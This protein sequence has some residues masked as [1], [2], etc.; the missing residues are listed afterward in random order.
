MK[1]N[2]ERIIQLLERIEELRRRGVLRE[3]EYEE[4]RA[5]L[6]RQLK[7]VKPLRRKD[8]IGLLL[9]IMA[10][11]L[12]IIG[13]IMSSL[14]STTITMTPAA[15][16]VT[17][18]STTTTTMRGKFLEKASCS[19]NPGEFVVIEMS[20]GSL[21]RWPKFAKEGQA[22]IVAETI[23]V[24]PEGLTTI[25]GTETV[26]YTAPVSTTRTTTIGPTGFII[27]AEGKQYRL[28]SNVPLI[29][30][31]IYSSQPIDFYILDLENYVKFLEHKPFEA[32]YAYLDIV[33]EKRIEFTPPDYARWRQWPIDTIRVVFLN[34]GGGMADVR[35]ELDTVW[36]VTVAEPSKILITTTKTE[37]RLTFPLIGL[38]LAIIIL[39][40]IVLLS[41]TL[42][43]RA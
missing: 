31:Y 6:L 2:E 34:K 40:I 12:I 35:Y 30:G 20:A 16:T 25:Y 15:E 28:M 27:E 9:K 19:I 33:G 38:G 13:V 17:L 24:G 10:I 37:Q 32:I 21:Y 41:M 7:E 14:P 3:D 39:G 23:K 22:T 29:S 36:P 4:M 42:T 26:T 43:K 11:A 5:S 8:N 18:T 1:N